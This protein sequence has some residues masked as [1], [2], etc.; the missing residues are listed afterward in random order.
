MV[1][2]QK[3]QQIWDSII[4]STL[5]KVYIKKVNHFNLTRLLKVTGIIL[6][7]KM[8]LKIGGNMCILMQ[9]CNKN[10]C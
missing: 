1:L 4:V 3:W 6:L 10:D 9:L 8:G 7:N 5:L 2:K